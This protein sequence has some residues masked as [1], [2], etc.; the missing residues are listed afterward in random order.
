MTKRNVCG[1]KCCQAHLYQWRYKLT[2]LS[3]WPLHQIKTLLSNQ[4]WGNM[5][6]F[7]FTWS[8]ICLCSY[9]NTI[10]VHI[11]TLRARVIPT[12]PCTQTHTYSGDSETERDRKSRSLASINALQMGVNPL[13]A[14][15]DY[16]FLQGPFLMPLHSFLF[17]SHINPKPP[18]QLPRMQVRTCTEIIPIYKSWDSRHLNSFTVTKSGYRPP[19]GWCC[20]IETD[21][22]PVKV[23]ELRCLSAVKQ[24]FIVMLLPSS[25]CW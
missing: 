16:C 11:R 2:E 20:C 4:K 10:C 7:I 8:L 22:R 24:S 17:L 9:I 5:H 25:D 13:P 23:E 14:H 6:L 19:V 21:A 18:K 3:L 12:P 15:C 1:D